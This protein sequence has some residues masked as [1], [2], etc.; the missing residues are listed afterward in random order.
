M[1]DGSCLWPSI[2]ERHEPIENDQRGVLGRAHAASEAALTED[3][4]IRPRLAALLVLRQPYA[5]CH[6]SSNGAEASLAMPPHAEMNA[7]SFLVSPQMRMLASR[8][9]ARRPKVVVRIK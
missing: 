4:F 9:G 6:Q 8:I 5:L 1:N 3:P 2:F 7:P